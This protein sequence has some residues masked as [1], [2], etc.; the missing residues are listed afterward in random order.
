MKSLISLINVKLF[1]RRE[2]SS[3]NYWNERYQSGG[4]SGPGSYGELA[5]FKAGVLNRFVTDNSIASVIEFGCGDGH[6]LT[7]AQYPRYAGY[8]I[9]PVAVEACRALF[10]DD[11][12]KRFFLSQEYDGRKADLAISI[13]VVFHLTEDT[14]FDAYM[15]RLFDASL[16]HVIIYSSNQD[17]PIEPVSNHVRHRRFT[18]WIDREIPSNWALVDRIKNAF[19]YTG[20][21]QSTSFSDF[22]I[23]GKLNTGGTES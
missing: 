9:S 17:E 23:Y 11:D 21:Y 16:R 12:S 5:K 18:D 22:F 7:L 8:D 19:P 15:R 4:N 2:F 6:Q 3:S 13:D 10:G 14:V 1:P 20:D